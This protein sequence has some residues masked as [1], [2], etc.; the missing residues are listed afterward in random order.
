MIFV[1][2]NVLID[3]FD[4]KDPAWSAW[5][6]RMIEELPPPLVINPIVV[7]ETARRFAALD[8]L[9]RF[10]AEIGIEILPVPNEAAFIAGH[11]H[12]AYRRNGGQREAILADFLIAGHATMLGAS[13]LTRDRGRF[14][15]YFPDLALITPETENG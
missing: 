8:G 10:L 13:L 1:D 3:L 14:S 6:Q 5:S 7:A 11:A 2:S 4:R 12:A 15:T 9:L